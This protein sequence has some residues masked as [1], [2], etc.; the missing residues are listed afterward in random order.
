MILTNPCSP[1]LTQAMLELAT[2]NVTPESGLHTTYETYMQNIS[3]NVNIRV[4][5]VNNRQN[6]PL[7]CRHL[8]DGGCDTTSTDLF[9]YT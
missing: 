7:P 4:G 2:K 1:T 5:T 6:K 8:L 9:A 3:P